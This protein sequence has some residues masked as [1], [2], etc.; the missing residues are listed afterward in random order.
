MDKLT[1]IL[2]IVID[3]VFLARPTFFPLELYWKILIL[4]EKSPFTF[5]SVKK[6]PG[7]NFCKKN[8]S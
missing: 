8:R 5:F 3:P 6:V 2:P 7:Q 4:R 1:R